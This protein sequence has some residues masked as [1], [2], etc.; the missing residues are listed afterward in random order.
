VR[1]A[2]IDPLGRAVFFQRKHSAPEPQGSQWVDRRGPYRTL[3]REAGQLSVVLSGPEVASIGAELVDISAHG[4]GVRIPG[5][6]RVELIGGDLYHV[7]IGSLAHPDIVTP[8]QLRSTIEDRASWRYGFEFIDLGGLY[9]Q[10][11]D[12]FVRYLNR[13]H[14]ERMRLVGKDRIPLVM[15]WPGGRR[16]VQVFDVSRTGMSFGLLPQDLPALEEG[17][18]VSVRFRLPGRAAE[19]VGEA[20]L[21]RMTLLAERFVLGL[22]FDFDHPEGLALRREELDAYIDERLRLRDAWNSLGDAKSARS[23]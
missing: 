14:D 11:D 3:P 12:F 6:R 21:A 22:A 18:R 19:H 20:E 2:T 16:A 23:A 5:R 9:D 15:E 1:R 4:I 17:A 8:V 13:R 10:L 7:T